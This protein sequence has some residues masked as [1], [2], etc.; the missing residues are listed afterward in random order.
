M[1]SNRIKLA[2]AGAAVLAAAQAG[3]AFA[4]SDTL[5]DDFFAESMQRMEMMKMFDANHDHKVT[6]DEF[7]NHAAA[8]FARMDTNGDGAI[9]ESEW[10]KLTGLVTGS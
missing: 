9:D 6:H 3:S 8:M 2:L 1:K 5:W 4:T 7:M 10:T